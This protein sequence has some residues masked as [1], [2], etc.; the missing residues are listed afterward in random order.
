MVNNDGLIPATA[1]T[2]DNTYYS[3]AIAHG[4]IASAFE[5]VY[6]PMEITNCGTITATA[7]AGSG[8]NANDNQADAYGISAYNYD[9]NIDITNTGTITATAS[10][11][12]YYGYSN[13]V[14][15]DAIVAVDGYGTINI[16]NDGLISA[17][18]E[19]RHRRACAQRRLLRQLR[20][21]HRHHLRDRGRHG[22]RPVAGGQLRQLRLQ[23]RP[24][25]RDRR[26][27]QRRHQHLVRPVGRQ[28]LQLRHR[29]R[30]AVDGCLRR[31][32][33][34]GDGGV[35]NPGTTP[36]DLG[37]GDDSIVNVGTIN[38]AN[39]VI[40]MGTYSVYPSRGQS[41]RPARR[42]VPDGRHRRPVPLPCRRIPQSRRPLFG[43]CRHPVG[44]NDSSA[45]VG[46]ADCDRSTDATTG[47]GD[48][49]DFTLQS[50]HPEFGSR[51]EIDYRV[52]ESH[53]A[54]LHSIV[55]EESASTIAQA[56]PG[57]VENTR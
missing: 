6:Q 49:R 53:Y 4:V 22:H 35:W 32:L 28:D 11:G 19:H 16:T 40:H 18:A 5:G 51:F 45:L 10:A 34:N 14:G 30:R 42:S 29:H 57:C 43:R 8:D 39:S 12:G 15:V 7:T 50:P 38:M 2:G 41:K 37:D 48:Q 26:R 54:I 36:T 21:Q 31:P 27:L 52:A 46:E 23:R 13:A 3:S 9:G 55:K 44:H 24:D 17:T 47:A 56:R 25:Q 1:S 33:Y 20:Q